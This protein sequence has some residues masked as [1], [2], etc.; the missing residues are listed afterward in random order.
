MQFDGVIA[1][2]I[3]RLN[4]SNEMKESWMERKSEPTYF[5]ASLQALKVSFSSVGL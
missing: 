1:V 4:G 2:M 5:Q 3:A